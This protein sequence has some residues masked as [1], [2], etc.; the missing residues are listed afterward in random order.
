MWVQDGVRHSLPLPFPP[1]PAQLLGFLAKT[2]LG[3]F[4]MGCNNKMT[5]NIQGGKR[6]SWKQGKRHFSLIPDN[7]KS[8]KLNSWTKGACVLIYNSKNSPYC[9]HEDFQTAVRWKPFPN[10]VLHSNHLN[11]RTAFSRKVVK[12][13]WKAAGEQLEPHWF[14]MYNCHVILCITRYFRSVTIL[15]NISSNFT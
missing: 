5:S 13:K 3:W 9:L 1:L 10:Y 7:S 2:T 12:I 4:V 14:K 11:S 6:C 15:Y 8:K